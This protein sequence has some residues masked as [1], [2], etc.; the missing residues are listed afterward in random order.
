MIILYGILMAAAVGTGANDDD[1]PMRPPPLD[2]ATMQSSKDVKSIVIDD[3]KRTAN[4]LLKDGSAVRVINMGCQHSGSIARS[5]VMNPP[6][7][8]DDA[9]WTKE[10]DRL[11]SIA[12]TPGEAKRFISWAA[13]NKLQKDNDRLGR[14]GTHEGDLM[15]YSIEVEPADLAMGTWLTISYSYP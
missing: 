2:V 12:F 11:A 6:S 1:C 5:W 4:L 9:A 15:Y 10:A 3:P 14:D 8:S 7:L 13:Q